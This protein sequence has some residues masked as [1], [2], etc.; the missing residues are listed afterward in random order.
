M[1]V[2]RRHLIH[3]ILV[4]PCIATTDN[5]FE[6]KKV[7]LEDWNISPKSIH[8]F[9]STIE[10]ALACQISST[11]SAMTYDKSTNLCTLATLS[12]YSLEMRLAWASSH[13]SMVYTS[14]KSEGEPGF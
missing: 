1:N 3:I 6:A 5:L 13:Y 8:S 12:H 11:C 14:N 9:E 10:C 2:M 7:F 4:S